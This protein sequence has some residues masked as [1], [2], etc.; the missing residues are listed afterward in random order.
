MGKLHAPIPAKL[1]V[2]MISRDPGLFQTCT[3]RLAGAFGPVD[4]RSEILPWEHSDYYRDEMGTD[5]RRK[6]IFFERLID[7]GDLSRIKLHTMQLERELSLV[8][9]KRAVNLDPGYITE[10]KVV[11]ATAK[12]FP[13]RIY[14]GEG[15]YAESTLHYSK[16]S[17]SYIAVD[18]TYPDFRSQYNRDLFNKAREKLRTTLHSE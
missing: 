12:D 15:I 14:I 1:F 6:F 8:A 2:G 9:A 7:P 16:N 5:L 4:I 3:E 10:A 13:H 11:L 18:H 17:G